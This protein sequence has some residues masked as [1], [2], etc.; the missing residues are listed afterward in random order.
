[1]IIGHSKCIFHVHKSHLEDYHIE[2][3]V[4]YNDD[5]PH[6]YLR[7]LFRYPSIA[8]HVSPTKAITIQG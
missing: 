1:M 3:Y 2:R 4:S 8:I 5:A 7:S 6:I